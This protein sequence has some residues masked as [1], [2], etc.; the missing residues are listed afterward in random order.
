MIRRCFLTI[1]ILALNISLGVAQLS[2]SSP[3]D[4]AKDSGAD[5]AVFAVD[6]NALLLAGLDAYRSDKVQTA[7]D[8]WKQ[9]L[10]LAPN[11]TLARVYQR[12]ARQVHVHRVTE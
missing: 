12:F 1:A 5:T 9:S 7:L 6:P 10:D 8:Y 3:S 2:A 11:P 4:A